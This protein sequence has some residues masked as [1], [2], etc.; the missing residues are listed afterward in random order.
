MAY[1]ITKHR[2]G[3]TQEWFDLDLI[4]EDG[5]L[6]IE[7]AAGNIRKCKIGD[8]IT[9]FSELPYITDHEVIELTNRIFTVQEQLL[10]VRADFANLTTKV[11]DNMA[12]CEGVFDEIRT[13]IS[14]LSEAFEQ[15]KSDSDSKPEFDTDA[16]LDGDYSDILPSLGGLEDRLQSFESQ[17]ADLQSSLDSLAGD[18]ESAQGDIAK[19]TA[20]IA[21]NTAL[22][23]QLNTTLTDTNTELLVQTNRISQIVALEEGSTTGDAELLNIRVGYNGVDHATAGDA[24]RAIGNDLDALKASLPSYIPANA[25]DGL[26]YENNQLWLTSKDTPV[27]EPVTITGG[28]G[29][30]SI[31]VVKVLNNLPSISFTVSRGNTAWINFTYTSF[32]DGVA[33][34]DGIYYITINDKKIDSLSGSIQ[35]GV[36]KSLDVSG[37]LKNGSNSVKVTCADQYGTA[38]SLVYTISVVELRIESTFNSAQIFNDTITFRYKP[39][40]QVEKTVQVLVD[41]EVVSEKKLSKDVSGNEIT[42]SIPKQPH[43]CHKIKAYIFATIGDDNEYVESNCLEYEIICTEPNDNTSIIASAYAVQEVS[44]G[45]LI[46]IPYIVYDPAQITSNIDL[47]IYSQVAGELKEID[48]SSISVGRTL[49][50]WNARKYP[51][52][53]AVFTISYTYELYGELTT[54]TKSHSIKVT[55]LDVDVTPEDDSLQL[56]LTAQGHSNSEQNPAVWTYTQPPS[57]DKVYETI[58]T[59][60]EGFNWKSNGWVTDAT[61]DT[62]LRLNGDARAT[63]NFKPFAEDFK[64]LGKTI[65]FEYVVRD[66]NDRSAIV[67]DCFDGVRGFRATPDTAFLKSSGTEVACRYKDE[68]RVRVSITVEHSDTTSRFVSIYL[69]GVLSGVQRYAT[70]DI[71]RQDN[72]INITLGSSLCGL[73]VYNIR[74]YNKALETAAVLNN[75][76]A[77]QTV[78]ATRLQL[79]TNNDILEDNK[80]SYERVKALGQ[81]PII[82][83]TGPMPTY[84]GDKKKKTTRMKFEDSA[85]PEMNFDVLLDQI[86]VQGTSSQF[87]IRKNWKV[88]L[89]EARAHIP[90]AIPAKVF[91]I[92]VDYAEA[93]GT[94]NT[95]SANYIETLYDREEVTLPPQKDD[96]RVRTTIQGFPIII[97]EKET[98]DS[99]PVFSSK[100]NFN[101]DKDAENAFGF[102]EDY[103]DFGVECWEFCNNTSDPVNF[104]GEIP[105][106]WLEDFEPRYVPKSANFERI[107]ELQEIADL[108]ASGK[109]I[110][111]EAQ[112]TELATL[113]RTCIANFKAMHDWV[114]STATYT[115]VDGKRVPIVAKPL[116]TPV[117]Y[118]ETTY[119]EDDETYRLAKFKYEFTDYFNMHYSSMYYVFTFFALMTDQRAKNMFLTRWKDSDGVHR[120]YPYF[121]DNDTIFGIN[122]EGA[123][124]FDYYHEDIDKLGSSN[125]FNGQNSVL[126]DNF[127]LCFPKEIEDTYSALRSSKKLTY[128]KIIDQFV[129]Q[130]SDKW[131][132]AI[133]NA[134][135]DYKYVSMARGHVD[136]TD[137]E[138]NQV[139]GVDASNLY[140]VRGTGEQ[141][142]R[143]FIDNRLN[144]CDSKWSSGDYP[145]NFFFLRIYTPSTSITDE[146]AENKTD[147]EL[148]AEFGEEQVRIYK[149]LKAV[150]ACPNITVTPF[151]AM[152]AGVRYKSGT[153]Q[154]ERLSA[155][156][157]HTF[158]PINT[159]ETFGDTETAIYGASELASLGDLSGLYCGVVNLKGQNTGNTNAT[160]GTV[161]ENK[162]VELIIGNPNPDY[163]NDNFR[164]IAVGTCKLLKTIDLRNCAGLGIAGENPQKTLELSGCPN[165][166]CIYAE[167]TNL[168]S[169][170]L[171]ESGYVKILHLPASTNTLVLKNQHYLYPPR[172]EL[173]TPE[174]K[175]GFFIESYQNIKTLCIE[176]CPNLDTSTVLEACRDA[177]GKYT[178]ERVRLTGIEW[179]TKDNPLPNADF[180]KSLFPVYD[181]NGNLIS[182]IRGIDEK[183]N[184]LEDAYLEGSCYIEELSG[185][186]YEAI[187]EHYKFLDIKFGR[188]TSIVTF[189]YPDI[190]GNIQTKTVE[191]SGENSSKGEITSDTLDSLTMT[192]VW[193]ENDAF[194]Y[195]LDS[196]SYADPAQTSQGI[197]D[198]E[199]DYLKY[200]RPDALKNIVGNRTLRPVF[201]AIRKSY[202][203]QFI[204]PTNNNELLYVAEVP[205]GSDAVYAGETPKKMDVG[206]AS[207]L[208]SFVGWHPSPDN[209]T[210]SLMCEAQFSY[211]TEWYDLR[212]TDISD[213][214]DIQGNITNGYQ[215][216]KQNS[217]ISITICKNKLNRAVSIPEAFTILGNKYTVTS[218]GGFNNYTNLA[219]ITLPKTLLAIQLRAFDGCTNL[220][221]L[222][223]PDNLQT[224]GAYAFQSCSSLRNVT[225]PAQ[226][227]SIG[228]AAF[229]GC[230]KFTKFQVDPKNTSYGT[231]QDGKLLL[232][233]SDDVLVQ[234]L[235]GTKLDQS[236]T[237]TYNRIKKLGAACLSNTDIAIVEIPTGISIIPTN[238]FSSCPKLTSVTLPDTITSLESSCFAWCSSLSSINLPNSLTTISTYALNSCAV[239]EVEI[240][241]SVSVIQSGA[242]GNNKHLKTVTFK[243]RRDANNKVIVPNIYN[244]AFTGS[245][246]E[247]V[248]FNVP[249][250]EGE[251]PAAP[252]GAPNATIN[253]AYEEESL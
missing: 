57:A 221:E 112:R 22:I 44:Q 28:T 150:P 168:T 50:Y 160:Q 173:G 52:G 6:V 123:L 199:E 75:Y 42:L 23:D 3:T 222:A 219:L 183:N 146:V 193:P 93:T 118:G 58:T 59:S 157:D 238:A 99:E 26:H 46:S 66:V 202:K 100:G 12:S 242:F 107:E 226:V 129:T 213:C 169:V 89:P 124:V 128:E 179:G 148:I 161:K 182:G 252:W 229:A 195:E 233:L 15:F 145:S 174:F 65:E 130:G 103:K 190:D 137:S 144:Y 84:K 211:D 154:Q 108:A 116:T 149:S 36:A 24:V 227:N 215:L 63:I 96:T 110:I 248:V 18:I 21:S 119:I 166:E 5:E 253:Y 237:D 17:L 143:Y 131:S 209:I 139:T 71:F 241:A 214:T 88:K 90:G 181:P 198:S 1:R 32:E 55:P 207:D 240:P 117:T 201:R 125:I 9:P 163:Y 95:G 31:S 10:T 158:T 245:G 189:E 170:D 152:Y 151:S 79:L 249:W 225:I 136:H 165:I 135:A 121:Y 94:H 104:A 175:D 223:L 49:Q 239:E 212:L 77:D 220:T 64:E 234:G 127:R 43:G 35:H 153:L 39:F 208:Y 206:A 48:R 98:E 228:S 20:N 172:G 111:T 91:C 122:N 92:K 56:Y 83:F 40:G 140:Q 109:G 80:V 105:D 14:Q 53:T 180:I 115:L 34:G 19:N 196:W 61:G 82:T 8:G 126:W 250:Q 244:D 147:A 232:G 41:A 76:I 142:L 176:N 85:H 192:P 113:M 138:G 164:E 200:V 86:D 97:F 101:Y 178:V 81:I 25:V 246:L 7:E 159:A 134:D 162:L 29:G 33:T 194:T 203:V 217:T 235:S 155:G 218:V 187:K 120:W 62:C 132:E 106:E 177:S 230:T 188:M 70:T 185:E 210:G 4:P 37:Y 87:Y 243:A 114:L 47:I 236:Q 60:F 38:R 141:H 205:Y 216:N 167:G 171:P 51:N 73:D 78:P 231:L 72:P 27:G 45:D 54:I 69:D 186:D 13:T 133:Y 30:G 68:E 197:N 224:I 11:N 191:I 74:V 251:S 247:G 2:R 184:L 102:T 67:I 16:G 204:N 156:E